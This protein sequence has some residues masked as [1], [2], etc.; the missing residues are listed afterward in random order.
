MLHGNASTK[1]PLIRIYNC[2]ESFSF[3][4]FSIQQKEDIACVIASLLMA[5]KCLG[6]NAIV[7][8]LHRDMHLLVLAWLGLVELVWPSQLFTKQ[9]NVVYKL[10]RIL[11]LLYFIS[12]SFSLL[13]LISTSR[14]DKVWYGHWSKLDNKNTIKWKCCRCCPL[15]TKFLSD[16]QKTAT[17]ICELHIFFLNTKKNHTSIFKLPIWQWRLSILYHMSLHLLD[18]NAIILIANRSKNCTLT[19]NEAHYITY[20]CMWISYKLDFTVN[21]VLLHWINRLCLN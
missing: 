13:F 10:I 20:I 16:T 7:Y 6:W 1:I 9:Y 21:A 15:Q 18:L 5:L 3:A 4:A 19:D 12:K 8:I 2:L 17:H 14:Y 11:Q